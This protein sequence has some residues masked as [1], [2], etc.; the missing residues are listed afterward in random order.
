[1]LLRISGTPLLAIPGGRK[2]VLVHKAQIVI[3][4]IEES[5]KLVKYW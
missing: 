1:M 2:Y 4:T 5:K 3:L